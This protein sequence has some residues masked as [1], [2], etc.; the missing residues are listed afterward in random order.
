MAL[1]IAYL[2]LRNAQALKQLRMLDW[3]LNHLHSHMHKNVT[4]DLALPNAPH[5]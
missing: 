3:Q 2:G 5:L 1:G 4:Q